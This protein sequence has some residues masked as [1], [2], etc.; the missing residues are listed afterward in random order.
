M[1]PAAQKVMSRRLQETDGLLMLRE[2]GMQKKKRRKRREGERKSS[3]LSM[4]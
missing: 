1:L 2:E 3:R 4:R